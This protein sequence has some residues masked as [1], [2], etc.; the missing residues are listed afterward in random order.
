MAPHSFPNRSWPEK[1]V[2]E[3]IDQLSSGGEDYR[4]LVERL[5]AIIYTAEMGEHGPWRYV[6]PQVEEILGYSPEAWMANPELWAELL[7]PDDRERALEQETRRTLGD[8]NPPPVDYRMVTR[9]GETVWILDEAVL[10]EDETGVPV[11][12]GVLY[13]ITERKSAEQELQRAAAQQATVAR[14]GEMAL[15]DGDPETL[16]TAAASLMTETDGVDNACVWQVDRDG[17]RL[18]LRAGLRGQGVAAPT[19]AS[20]RPATPTPAPRSSPA[21]T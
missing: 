9:E 2:T 4:R 19:S 13:D 16:M 3:F 11:W 21:C 5:P 14:L 10:E 8:R 12:H 1:T 20:R 6:S 15:R 7:H 17:R 18:H